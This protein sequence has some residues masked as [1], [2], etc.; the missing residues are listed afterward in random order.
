M[1]SR[2]MSVSLL[3]TGDFIRA[4]P[5]HDEAIALYDPAKHR[6]LATRFGQDGGVSILG[7]RS[8]TL[9]LLGYPEAAFADV[10]QAVRYGREIGQAASLMFA[11][12]V[13]SVPLSQCGNYTEANAL[14]SEL[15]SL[16]DEK[17]SLFWK[18][19][20]MCLLGTV[21]TMTG[22]AANAVQMLTSGLSAYRSTG[23]TLHIPYYLA[24]LANS[25]A[26]LGELD[27]AWSC[28]GEA[29]AV[30]DT[31][32]QRW[33]EAEVNRIA[34]E[35]ALKAPE[36]D[37]AK[38]ET[39]FERALGVARQQ[40]AKSWELRAAMSLTR[41]WRD[42]GKPQQARELLAPVYGWFT[43]GFD[44]RDLKDARR[45]WRSSR[46]EHVPVCVR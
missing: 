43:E 36:P 4:R 20:G 39:Y 33:C 19:V 45:C 17:T 6:Q 2:V 31:T 38:A 18:A 9:W 29:T 41:L 44:T 13:G 34:G 28:I 1:G 27:N 37:T 32:D 8:W 30:I 15:V 16:A 23:A 46:H 3:L 25:Y 35:V 21:A 5:F 42:K 26:E 12:Y 11:L 7:F 10:E 14:S 40:Q 24:C 22:E